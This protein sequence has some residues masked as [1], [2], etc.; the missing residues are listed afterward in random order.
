VHGDPGALEL[1]L[2]GGKLTG[3]GDGEA[4]GDDAGWSLDEGEAVV[5]VVGAQVRDTDLGGGSQFQADD[6]GGEADGRVK[7]GHAG[8]D[9]GDVGERDHRTASGVD[10]GDVDVDLPVAD[11]VAVVDQDVRVGRYNALAIL[12][13]VLDVDLRDDRV[14]DLPGVPDV[15]GQAVNGGEEAGDGF[16]DGLA[17]GDRIGVA[18]AERHVR[19]EMGDELVGVEGIDVGEGLRYVAAHDV[20]PSLE[21]GD[22]HLLKLYAVILGARNACGLNCIHICCCPRRGG[23]SRGCRRPRGGRGSACIRV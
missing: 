10:R 13:Q 4:G 11:Q 7:V 2:G 5:A 18:E 17:A 16:P 14:P 6:A 3:A 15:V 20:L 12:A 1:G 21:V 23:V 19:G 8:T 22:N 9:V